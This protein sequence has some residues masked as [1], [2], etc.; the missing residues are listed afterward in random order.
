MTQ[1]TTS[2]VMLTIGLDLGDRKLHLCALD[3][4]RS[5]VRRK[6]L[7]ATRD[8]LVR[9]FTGMPRSRLV[10]EAGPQSLWMS[11]LL[12][13]LGHDVLVVNPRRVQLISQGG[14]KTAWFARDN[15]L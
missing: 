5:V 14:R 4:Q 15:P 9:E 7:G 10:M 11:V 3:E 6:E 13:E 2:S 1:P 12:R 8:S